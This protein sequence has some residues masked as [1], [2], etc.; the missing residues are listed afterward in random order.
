ME[1]KD[2]YKTLGVGRQAS[3][4]EIKKAYR[5]LAMQ[6]HP[7]RNPDNKEAESKF[8]EINEAYQALGDPEKRSHYDR[9]GS[10]YAQWQRQGAGGGFNWG[11]WTSGQQGQRQSPGNVR[12]EYAGNMDDLFGQEGGFSDFFQQIFGGLGGRESGRGRPARQPAYEQP[13]T[14]TLEEAFHGGKRLMQMDGRRLE[15]KIP[16]GAVSGTRIRMS[17]AGPAGR[18]GQGSD[19]YLVV[20]VAPDARFTV[21]GED[22]HTEVET[23][24]VTA[25]L[26][27]ELRVPTLEGDVILRVP[28]G[29]Q[30]GQSIRIKGKGLPKLKSNKERGDLFAKIK[31][32]IPKE[33]SP[34]QRELFEK[35]SELKEQPSN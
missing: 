12:V 26:G 3:Q 27:G 13:V 23:E 7:D 4:A 10:E 2:Y 25:V 17:G 6:F 34:K 28:A 14:I 21:S 29:T 11:Q 1:Y 5:K 33:L 32:R 15:V 8:K 18:G 9:L 30:P 35:L 19:I 16:A 24:L 20:D 22:L 31:V